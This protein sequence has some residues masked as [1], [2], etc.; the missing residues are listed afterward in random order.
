MSK[1]IDLHGACELL[2]EHDDILILAHQKPD[3]DTLGSAFALLW[4]LET[5]GKR[6]RVECSDPFPANYRVVIGEY[7]PAQFTPRFVASVDIANPDL[8]GTLQETWQDKIDLCIDHHQV[9]TMSAAHSFIDPTAAA[10]AEIAYRIVRELGVPFDCRIA[11]AVFLGLST[12][13][14]CFRYP[15]VSAQTHRIAAE[16]IEAGAPHGEINRVMFETRSRA[17]I[18]LDKLILNTLEYHFGG[19]CAMVVITREATHSL[20]IAEHELDGVS[21]I[22]RRIEG[23]EVGIVMREVEGGWRI[24]VRTRD[25]VDSCALCSNFGGGGHKAAGGCTIREDEQT[26]RKLLLPAIENALI[27]ARLLPQ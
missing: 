20:G 17:L 18:E 13:T 14:G 22:P 11:G 26:A 1:K 3:G 24:S 16:M 21:A 25:K 23:V 6:A 27:K 19:L 4:A 10:T 15:N 12:D 8:L 9:N 5:L 7:S 2:R